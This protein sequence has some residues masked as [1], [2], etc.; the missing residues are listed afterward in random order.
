M[1]VLSLAYFVSVVLESFL[2]C[3]PVAY[4]WNKSIDGTCKDPSLGYL[5]AAITN[6]LIDVIIVFLP[7]PLLWKLQMQLTKKIAI[8]GMFSLGLV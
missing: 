5:L 7:L 2:F 4:N 6:L 8:T 3:R 1:V